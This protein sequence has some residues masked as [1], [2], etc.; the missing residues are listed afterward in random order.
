MRL[1]HWTIEQPY[2]Q[3]YFKQ[4]YEYENNDHLFSQLRAWN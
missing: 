1:L 2:I 4:G 3:W